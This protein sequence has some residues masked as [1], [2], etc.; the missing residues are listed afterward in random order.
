ME[1]THVVC[2]TRNGAVVHEVKVPSTPAGIAAALAGVPACRWVLFETGWMALMI[3]QGSSQLGLPVIASRAG[4]TYQALRL[5]A[6]HKTAT[7]M[8]AAWRISPASAFF[9]P[10]HVK[11]LPARAV[12]S[13]IIARKKLPASGHS[14][15]P[16]PRSCAVVF[17]VRLPLPSSNRP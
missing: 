4:R 5:L 12:R 11:S 8:H 13:L 1:E 15:K 17:G 10:V 9:K 7:T 14:R 3:Y 2:V 16:D 6:T